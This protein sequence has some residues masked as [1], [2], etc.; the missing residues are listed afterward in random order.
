ME[1]LEPEDI[2]AVADEENSVIVHSTV[3]I[4][5]SDGMS[6]WLID[7]RTITPNEAN[8]KARPGETAAQRR[9]RI[10][11]M[12]ASLEANG[13]L[14]PVLV[15]EVE[16][17]Y[18]YV[19][20]GCR[21][22]AA[23]ELGWE[24]VWAAKVDSE[25]DLF[26]TA[27]ISNLHRTQ[28]TLLDMAEICREVRERFGWGGKQGGQ[29]KVAEYLGIDA[30]RVSE[31]EKLLYAS[32]GIKAKI[33]SG[34]IGSLDAALKLL[35]AGK[36]KQEQVVSRA[37]E[38]AEEEEEAAVAP[39]SKPTAAKSST[40]VKPAPKIK[41]KHVEKALKEVTGKSHPATIT[42]VSE[43]FK[44]IIKPKSGYRMPAVMFA[45]DM[46]HWCQGAKGADAK[47]KESFDLL[48]GRVITAPASRTKAKST[49]KKPLPAGRGNSRKAVGRTSNSTKTASAGKGGR[50]QGRSKS[51]RKN[52]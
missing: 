24:Q 39:E 12:M 33:R 16:G 18:E 6:K 1:I 23:A 47:V 11:S 28:N 3:D 51:R 34:E 22:E 26:R 31:Y 41:A 45:S 49:I 14:S 35:S 40:T 8:E 9:A 30:P 32:E 2:E 21:V 52:K 19:D 10:T 48:A 50:G 5:L 43:F 25:D 46:V 37:A 17:G 36:D 20:G 4:P 13:Q 7:P 15:V 42:E 44:T 29:K 38:I 27:V